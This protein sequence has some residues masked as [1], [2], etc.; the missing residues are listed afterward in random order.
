MNILIL[1]NVAENVLEENSI[2]A[3]LRGTQSID[4]V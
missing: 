1:I 3:V 2:Q 4:L